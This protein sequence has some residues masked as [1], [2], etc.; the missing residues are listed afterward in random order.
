MGIKALL[1]GVSL[2]DRVHF[3]SHGIWNIIQ[4]KLSLL[5]SLMELLITEAILL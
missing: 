2:G 1:H 5:F 3:I 4:D